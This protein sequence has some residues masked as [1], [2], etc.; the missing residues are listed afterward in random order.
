MAQSNIRT[1]AVV[2]GRRRSTEDR[3]QVPDLHDRRPHGRVDLRDLRQRAGPHVHDDRR[4]S[5]SPTARPGCWSRSSTGSCASTGAGPP[6]SRSRSCC[7][8]WRRCSGSLLEL[9]I[10][11]GLQNTTEAV[12][13]VVSISLLLFL[14]GFAQLIWEPGREPADVDV[15]LVERSRSTSGRPRSPIHQ[16]ITIGVAI[17]VAIGLRAPAHPHRASGS[18]CAPRST[19]ARCP[20]STAPGPTGP[21]C[22]AWAIGTST[23]GA[24]RHPDRPRPRPRR[25]RRSRCSS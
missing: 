16:A 10:M 24:R 7:S 25:R 3:G 18:R 20:P 17:L 11:R 4:S 2:V 23:R 21:R 6:R 19:T 22:S 15:L 8:C 5:T 14:I 12:K 13:L 9:V 1:Y